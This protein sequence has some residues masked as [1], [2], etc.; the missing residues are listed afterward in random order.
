MIK[1]NFAREHERDYLHRNFVEDNRNYYESNLFQYWIGIRGKGETEEGR[2]VNQAIADMFQDVN[3]IEECVNHYAD[4]LFGKSPVFSVAGATNSSIEISEAVNREV[5]D[6]CN[7]LWQVSKKIITDDGHDTFYQAQVDVMIDGYAYLRICK[8]GERIIIHSPLPGSV[9][10]IL[11]NQFGKPQEIHY[12]FTETILNEKGKETEIEYVEVHKL[13]PD[14]MAM[15]TYVDSI[16]QAIDEEEKPSIVLDLNGELAIQEIRR[17]PFITPTMKSAQNALSHA[18]TMIPRNNDLSNYAK[19]YLNAKPPGKYV[20][21]E[22]TGD[23]EFQ[24][25]PNKI[26]VAPGIVNFVGGIPLKD[27]TGMIRGFTSPSVHVDEPIDISAFVAS[28]NFFIAIIYTAANLGHLIAK[29]LI[30]SGRSRSEMRNDFIVALQKDAERL[31]SFFASTFMTALLMNQAMLGK[32]VDIY[33]QIVINVKIV[34]NPGK[35]TPEEQDE[36]IKLFQAGLMSRQTA[37]ALLGYTD[38]ENAE[39]QR[40]E[41]ERKNEPPSNS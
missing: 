37:I 29:D 19:T 21:D 20:D 33:K 5:T 35:P 36:I 22:E 18:A 31:S 11:R 34:I 8:E 32:P 15:I 30:L 14:G 39:I 4:A 7:S 6:F 24:L 13:S 10:V 27:E 25:D 9:T 41:S 28:A 26:V 38:D 12:T 23:R 2:V 3:L 40:I 17:R 1:P 16:G